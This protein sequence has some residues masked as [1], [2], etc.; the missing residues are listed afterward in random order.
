MPIAISC[1]T[2]DWK[3]RV[4]DELAGKKGKC[5]SC[6]EPIPIPKKGTPP[7]IP[8]R[9]VDDAP[10][11]V[12]DDIIEDAEVVEQKSRPRWKETYRAGRRR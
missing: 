9:A 1:E 2:C 3:G 6:G 11:V 12:D 5:P 8:T 10:D 4:K 7:P